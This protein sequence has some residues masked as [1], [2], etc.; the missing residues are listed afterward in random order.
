MIAE[1]KACQ[2]AN[3]VNNADWGK[4]YLGGVPNSKNIWSTLQKGD[5]KAYRSA[6]VPWYNVHKMYAGLRDA[7]AYT[8]NEEAK[9][10]F[11]KFC[12]WGIDIT[13]ALSDTQMQSM[14]DMEHGGIN[15]IFADAFQITSDEKY[16]KAANR[17][18]HRMLLDAMASHTDNLDN[19]HANTQ[20][21][22]AVGFQ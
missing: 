22:K 2:E 8:G 4:G 3:G 21:P 15:E 7:W 5:F 11:L 1:L 13:T 19:K 14:L 10:I 20:V 9:V 6:W 18:S 12:D 17:F 16:L